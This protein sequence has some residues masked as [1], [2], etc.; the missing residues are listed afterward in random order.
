M[1]RVL[2]VCG[3]A[4]LGLGLAA[5]KFPELPPLDETDAANG[6]DGGGTDA[7]TDATICEGDRYGFTI[8]NVAH[9]DV[10]AAA[11]A[12]DLTN[13]AS[14]DTFSGTM[15]SVGG[16]TAP[17]PGTALVPQADGNMI[18]VVSAT[19]LMVPA[20]ASITLRG[21]NPIAFL[22]RGDAI[23]DGTLRLTGGVLQASG[24]AGTRGTCTTGGSGTGGTGAGL[25]GGGGGGA[26][27]TAGG[28]GGYGSNDT[29][30]AGQPGVPLAAA[31]RSPLA[32]GCAG[33]PGNAGVTPGAGGGAIQ[34]TA[35]GSI[36]IDGTVTAGGGGASGGGNTAGGGGGGSGGM[37]LLEAGTEVRGGGYLTANG[38]GGGGG[39][40]AG[41]NATAGAAGCA[42]CATP[43]FGGSASG[44]GAGFGGN[45]AAGG[46]GAM[47]GINSSAYAGGGG[48]GGVGVIWLRSSSVNFSGLV[49]PT[50]RTS[51][52]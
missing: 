25:G 26:L 11:T 24:P 50:A 2:R 43:A 39:G 48:G 23:V 22:V 45:G 52:L 31:S 33:S 18:R 44:S 17:L 29:T 19:S 42:Q 4:A 5:C 38:G 27:G 13:V 21:E 40:G 51:T 41:G 3:V 9:C 49:S 14:I 37:V 28:S 35:M 8:S 16:S 47:P 7:A 32:G 34:I 6:D 15:T 1:I 20:A 10:P 46:T 30:N 36:V 12:L